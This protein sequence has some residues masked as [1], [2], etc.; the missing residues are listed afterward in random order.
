N[1]SGTRSE[2]LRTVLNN[3]VCFIGSSCC[4]SELD[5]ISSKESS[6]RVFRFRTVC[7]EKFHAAVIL[8]V[9][10][11]V[12]GNDDILV[13]TGYTDICIST[14][15]IRSVRSTENYIVI[16]KPKVSGSFIKLHLEGYCWSC[17]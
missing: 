12:S 11:A 7:V 17:N 13:W 6:H 15:I 5:F 3:P 16:Y 9:C 2:S 14:I 4:P 1:C 8:Q 10:W